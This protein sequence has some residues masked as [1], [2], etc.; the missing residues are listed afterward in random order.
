MIEEANPVTK[1]YY[2]KITGV[3]MCSLIRKSAVFLSILTLLPLASASADRKKVP[4]ILMDRGTFDFSSET[5]AALTGDG[6]STHMGKIV[7][8]GEFN[9]VGN[10]PSGCFKGEISGTATDSNGDTLTYFLSA[11]FCPDPDSNPTPA[12]RIFYGVGT[13]RITG[14]TGKFERAKGFG[15]FI[16]LADFAGGTYNCFLRGTIFYK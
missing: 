7:S 15:E 3:H 10:R 14:G 11:Q 2:R 5:S 6:V 13:Y 4:L 9:N 12:L 16:G 8:S 1:E